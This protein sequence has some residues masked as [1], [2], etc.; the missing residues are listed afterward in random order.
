MTLRKIA[1]GLIGVTSLVGVWTL[2]L[3]LAGFGGEAQAKEEAATLAW[4]AAGPIKGMSCVQITEPADPQAWTSDYLCSSEDLGIR[5]SHAGPIP[6]MRCTAI[7]EPVEPKS[8]SWLDNYL[9]VPESSSYHFSW[10]SEGPIEGMS[11]VQ[12]AEPRDPDTWND[13][14]LCW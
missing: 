4:S 6:D 1:T 8:E 9:C 13:N 7:T 5:W 11:C 10:S 3:H 2:G 14:Y 12:W